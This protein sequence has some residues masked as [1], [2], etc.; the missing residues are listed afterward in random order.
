MNKI[1]NEGE[2]VSSGQKQFGMLCFANARH[3]CS[4]PVNGKDFKS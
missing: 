2:D 3:T 4:H 1:Y